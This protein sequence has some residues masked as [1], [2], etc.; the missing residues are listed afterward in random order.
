VALRLC[1]IV[2]GHGDEAAVPV[3][4]RRVFDWF[5]ASARSLAGRRGLQPDLEPPNEPESIRGAKEWLT[6]HMLGAR[7]YTE[8]LDQAAFAAEMS[9][10]DARES[11]SFRKLWR[12]AE[13]LV[14]RS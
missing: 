3:L 11:S 7:A 10:A 12:D 2:E 8:T 6:W 9:L 1:P 4:L 5:L 14:A 13:R